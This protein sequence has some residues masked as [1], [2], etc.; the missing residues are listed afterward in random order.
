MQKTMK[1]SFY[2][3]CL[4][5]LVTAC[6]Q[7]SNQLT[8]TGTGVS[9]EEDLY[10]YDIAENKSVDTIKVTGGN[11]TYVREITGDPK[12]YLITDHV[13]MMHYFVAEKGRLTLT[14]DTGFIKG[15]PLNDRMADLIG[16]YR[17]AG[18]EF[19]QKKSALIESADEEGTDLTDEQI[20]ELQDLDKEQ[21]AEEA[22][23]VKKFY[24]KDKASVLGI[25]ELILL[26]GLVSEEAFISLYEQGGDMVKNFPSFSRIFETKKNMEKT[27]VGDRYVDLQGINPGDTTQT[28]RLSDFAGKGKY[29]LLD[30]WASWCGPCRA[31]MPEIK[32]LNDT[33]SG[34]DLEV[35]GLVVS[36]NIETHLQAAKASKVTW[37]Q[38]FDSKNEFVLLY[39]IKGIPTLILLDR[40]G[41]ILVRTHEKNEVIE[42][43]QDLLGK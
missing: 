30:F 28:V 43:I 4:C 25:F 8:L 3:V 7:E 31:A 42:K 15:T 38:I 9:V 29:V 41:T 14:G 20:L 39:G 18:K 24:E 35:I 34:K 2:S 12:L 36:D 26:Q 11:F 32:L 16:I 40:D 17:H 22:D 13:T 10:V 19:E 1:I 27:S 23:A 21:S 5:L 33:Y 37:P 6:K